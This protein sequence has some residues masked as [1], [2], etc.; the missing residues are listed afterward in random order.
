MDGTTDAGIPGAS[1]IQPSTEQNSASHLVVLTVCL[2]IIATALVLKPQGD[3][4]HI[5]PTRL[6]GL[7]VLKQTTGIPCPSCGLTRAVVSA[8]HG[9]WAASRA[10]HRLGPVVLLFL[11]LQVLYRTAWLG[12][13]PLRTKITRAG[14]ILDLALFPLMV[15]MLVNWIPTL[16]GLF[17]G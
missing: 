14:R 9:D 13:P 2:S 4:L 8:V 5:G 10:F 7:C 12:L 16:L 1:S 17:G 11:V 3:Q 15:L 6:P